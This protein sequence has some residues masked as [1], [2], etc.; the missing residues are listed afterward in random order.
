MQKQETPIWESGI[1]NAPLPPFV[2]EQ[3]NQDS[4]SSLQAAYYKLGPIFR[5]PREGQKPL[6]VLAGPEANAFTSRYGD[7]FFV[8]GELWKDFGN[9]MGDV[10]ESIAKMRDGQINHQRRMQ[11]G[12]DYARTKVLDQLPRMLKITQEYAQWETGQSI[13]VLPSMQ[14]IVA[15]QLGQLMVNYSVGDY[16]EDF[17]IYLSSSIV[18]SFGAKKREVLASPRFQQA[19]ERVFEVGRKIVEAHRAAPAHD[20]KPDLVDEALA[21]AAAQPET[22]TDARLAYV[23]LGPLLAGLETVARTNSYLLY[24]LLKNPQALKRVVDEADQAF[25]Q[26]TLSWEA[27]KSMQATQGAAMETLRLYNGSSFNA[28]VA[29]PFTFAGYRLEPGDEVKVAIAVSHHLPELFPHPETFDIDRYHD[30]RNEHRQRGAY[31]PFGLGE[32]TC[33]GAGIAEVQLMVITATLLHTYQFELDPPDYQ[34]ARGE[35]LSIE[36]D[37]HARAGKQF[38]LKIAARR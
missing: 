28:L 30:P 31:A 19:K 6:V 38:R 33:L 7:E 22:Y 14:R 5:L 18:S 26:G 21:K 9:A 24:A 20:R 23:G 37:I 3:E 12:R 25:V 17:V 16:L 32:H 2:D 35:Q 8:S 29:K 34:L 1:T 15:E 36:D 11:A 13:E 4:T 10:S 27:L